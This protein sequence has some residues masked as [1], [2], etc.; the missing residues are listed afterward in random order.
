M[1]SAQRQRR[2]VEAPPTPGR[3][4]FSFSA[5]NLSRKSIP[6][7]W[8]DA[9][10]WLIGGSCHESPAHITKASDS[11]KI[12]RA[13]GVVGKKDDAFA[14]EKVSTSFQ[15]ETTFSSEVALRDK[16]T[17]NVEPPR[18]NFRYSDPTEESFLFRGSCCESV[19]AATTKV[20]SEARR[21]DVTPSSSIL[22]S[23]CHAPNKISSPARHNTPADMSGPLMTANTAL[24]ITELKDCHFAKLQL[25]A[26]YDSKNWDSREEEEA[27]V[28][29]SLRHS[30]NGGGRKSFAETRACQWEHEERIK[31]CIRYQREEAKIQAWV[32]LHSAKAEAQSKKLEMK[33]QKMRSNLEEKTMKRMA[34]VQRRAEEWRAAAQLQHSQQILR[35]SEQAQKMRTLQTS[36]VSCGCFPC[37]NHL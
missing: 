6:S 14:K 30:D 18:Q 9:E 20:A 29:K 32:N 8:D 1:A 34:I 19:R 27:E 22:A 33:I 25:S 15:G 26:Q 31:I 2:S 35:A 16:F 5:G 4:V 28:S 3:T 17:D 23:R 24:D 12:S 10:K 7:K 36:P 37:N 11:S 13:N 21:R